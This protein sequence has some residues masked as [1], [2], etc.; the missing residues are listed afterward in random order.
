MLLGYNT[1]GLAH[2]RLDEAIV[3]LHDEGY[4]AIALTLD[5]AHL[6]PCRAPS[7]EIAR[8]ARLLR[9]CQMASVVETGARFVL[10]P[11]RKHRPNLLE[12]DPTERR[13]RLGFLRRCLEIGAALE[14]RALSFWSGALPANVAPT[15]ARARLRDAIAELLPRAEQL[16]IPLAL[17]PEPGMLIET[18]ADAL[19]LCDELGTPAGLG[20][21]VDIGHLYVT[22]EGAPADVLRAARGRIHQVHI[23]D[24]CR[25]I[26][27]HLAPGEGEIDFAEVWAALAK[28]GY[29]GPVC[30][31]LSRSSHAA[32]DM[33][34]LAREVFESR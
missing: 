31:E 2:H 15:E 29:A 25:G 24:I 33:V 32:P 5:V 30:F 3:F 9:K 7:S 11:R 4:A 10:D 16:G 17:E 21:T 34:R 28:I 14:S 8:I 20:L 6:D 1:N 12:Q 13:K 26:H 19:S 27:E 23:E 18:V 22:H